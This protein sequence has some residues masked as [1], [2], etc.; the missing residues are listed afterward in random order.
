MG[1][2][3]F[4][5]GW[6]ISFLTHGTLGATAALLF[7]SV[8]LPER[9][10][11]SEMVI[12]VSTPPV[13]RPAETAPPSDSAPPPPMSKPVAAPS[14][15]SVVAHHPAVTEQVTT[16]RTVV[17]RQVVQVNAV[18]LSEAVAREATDDSTPIEQRSVEITRERPAERSAPVD[19]SIASS[20]ETTQA[21]SREPSH[22]AS[23]IESPPVSTVDVMQQVEAPTDVES[24]QPAEVMTPVVAEQKTVERPT[25]VQ[26]QVHADFGW[27]SAAL[28]ERI[29]QLKR[30]P[31]FAKARRW[32][33]RVV[34][35]ADI[36]DT[37]EIV[38]LQV[39]ESSGHPLLD[40]E[41]L[42]VVR[43][44]SPVPLRHQLGR[45]FVTIRVPITYKLQ[46]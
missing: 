35:E 6:L 29:E 34:V 4:W 25:L 12:A 39:A 31:S 33:G 13:S 1:K 38:R 44:S 20:Q 32:E 2:K 10:D 19:S 37:G 14:K 27:L 40:D 7:A 26:R 22:R 30:Y 43:K 28:R 17:A 9:R 18:A 36:R 21:I 5:I 8:E 15:P 42:T 45:A 16:S 46:G 3:Q 23:L 41:A 11:V 24:T